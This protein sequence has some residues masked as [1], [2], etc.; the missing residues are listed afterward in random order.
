MEIDLKKSGRKLYKIK[1]DVTLKKGLR[2]V[3]HGFLVSWVC[4]L[5]VRDLGDQSQYETLYAIYYHLHNLNNAKNTHE[6]VLLL[7]KLQISAKG[8]TPPWVF[9]CFLNCTNSKK[10]SQNI[11]HFHPKSI[12]S[13]L[14][15]T[16]ML[17]LIQSFQLGQG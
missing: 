7:V 14:F 1:S 15:Y 12:K 4:N 13:F 2:I 6:G 11:I 3:L 9:S 8:S 16:F 17:C 10:V 5:V